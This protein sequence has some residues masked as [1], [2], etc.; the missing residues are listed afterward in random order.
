M[1]S[2]LCDTCGHANVDSDQAGYVAG[3]S[4]YPPR[5]TDFVT[6]LFGD[7]VPPARAFY[8]G[9]WYKSPKAKSRGLAVHPIAWDGINCVH[10]NVEADCD[11][12]LAAWQARH[13]GA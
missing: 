9:A 10:G 7:G 3:C 1:S 4:H 8:D 2:F 13:G 6:V 5:H 12:C 11:R